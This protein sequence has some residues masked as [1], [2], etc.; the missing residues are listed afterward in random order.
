MEPYE[1]MR[2]TIMKGLATITVLLAAA[3]AAL[4][5]CARTDVTPQADGVTHVA[6]LSGD[7]VP[8]LHRVFPG[9]RP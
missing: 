6:G 3:T 7:V 1:T 8:K 4:F 9:A 5:A 2:G